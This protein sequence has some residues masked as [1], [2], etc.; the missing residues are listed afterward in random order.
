MFSNK[1]EFIVI[2]SNEILKWQLKLNDK[3]ENEKKE[4]SKVKH[5]VQLLNEEKEQEL[6]SL[7]EQVFL[8]FSE[9]IF[10]LIL[11]IDIKNLF[12]FLDM[13]S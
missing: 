6:V 9:L 2:H 1:T 8:S 7:K 13:P 3:E 12:C 4:A 5:I 11:Y 10:P